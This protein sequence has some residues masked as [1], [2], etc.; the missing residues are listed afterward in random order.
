MIVNG[1]VLA[2]IFGGGLLL[3]LLLLLIRRQVRA[4]SVSDGSVPPRETAALLGSMFG[5]PAGM[6]IYDKTLVSREVYVSRNDKH[7]G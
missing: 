2:G 3:W 4:G 6:W 1:L 5:F 7:P